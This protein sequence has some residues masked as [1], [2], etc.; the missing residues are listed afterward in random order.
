MG[1]YFG[2]YWGVPGACGHSFLVKSAQMH[3]RVKKFTYFCLRIKLLL[4]IT[5]LQICF[6]QIILQIILQFS[7]TP[8]FHHP[9]WKLWKTAC[10]IRFSAIEIDPILKF[11]TNISGRKPLAQVLD[12]SS[13]LEA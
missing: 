11:Y 8:S 5:F 1:E 3:A 9:D 10:W 4:Q 7:F 6:L 2:A 13:S 12:M